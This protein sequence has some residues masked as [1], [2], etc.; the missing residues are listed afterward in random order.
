MVIPS[1]IINSVKENSDL[2]DNRYF[3]HAIMALKS[4]D[5]VKEDIYCPDFVSMAANTLE[6]IYKGFLDTASTHCDDYQLPS[7]NFLDVDHDIYGMMAEIKTN[8][9]DLFPYQSRE[10]WRQ[11]KNFLRDLRS[12]Y[13]AAR[14][15]SYPTY[16]E[17]NIIRQYVKNQFTLIEEYLKE[18]KLLKNTEKEIPL[19]F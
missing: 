12:E 13:S 3:S 19:D 11:T 17:F 5:A 18:G 14:Y 4:L 15:S 8:F 1:T 6:R 16:E 7:L 10:E 9:P 2:M